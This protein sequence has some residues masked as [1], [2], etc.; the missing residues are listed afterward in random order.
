MKYNPKRKQRGWKVALAGL[1]L[2]AGVG[3]GCE[4]QI[5]RE[6]R[7]VYD[8]RGRAVANLLWDK[9]RGDVDYSNLNKCL[10][11]EGVFPIDESAKEHNAY[12]EVSNHVK[13][14][15]RIGEKVDGYWPLVSQSTGQM[16]AKIFYMPSADPSAE[17]PKN[18]QALQ[19]AY[20]AGINAAGLTEEEKEVIP[21]KCKGEGLADKI[22]GFLEKGKNAARDWWENG[23]E[24]DAEEVARKATQAVKKFWGDLTEDDSKKNPKRE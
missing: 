15:T 17:F 18:S 22:G 13:A 10:E 11:R 14:H 16:I 20:K 4:S 21:L 6:R 19:G 9:L 5:E 8:G 12:F 24:E 1:A 2:L 3:S 23:G 7:A